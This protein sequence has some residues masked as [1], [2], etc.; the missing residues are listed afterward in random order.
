MAS[1]TG[2]F[3]DRKVN[4]EIADD[5]EQTINVDFV[6]GHNV[7]LTSVDQGQTWSNEEHQGLGVDQVGVLL[8]EEE[9][10]TDKPKH[11][12]AAHKD[13]KKDDKKK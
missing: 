13:D 12:A 1:E 10:S 2:T 6:N 9:A 8:D 4:I 7:E 5:G 11:K 3:G